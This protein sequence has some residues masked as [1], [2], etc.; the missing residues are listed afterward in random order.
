MVT[1]SVEKDGQVVRGANPKHN[2]ILNQG[3]D[4]IASYSFADCFNYCAAGDSNVI[5]TK[6]DVAL[7]NELSRTGT[8]SATGSAN[9]AEL[10]NNVFKLFRT[11]EFAIEV[12]DVIYRE[13]GMSPFGVPGSNI[14]SKALLRDNAGDPI[15]VP[16]ATGE[17]LV[18]KYELYIEIFDAETQIG[19][20]INGRANSSGI[21]RIQKIGLKGIS[22][23]GDTEDYDVVGSCNEPSTQ[24]SMFISTDNSPPEPFGQC[25]DRSAGA[26]EDDGSISNYQAST[27]RRN[28]SLLIRP[29][30]LASS[31]RSVG[32]GPAANNGAVFVFDQDQNKESNKAYFIN[33]TYFWTKRNL[34]NFSPWL[35]FED[36]VYLSNRYN[37]QNSFAYFAL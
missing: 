11:F 8:K 26:Y 28:K 24:A 34:S 7:G 5:P 16:V 23:L 18:V 4:F 22:A 10:S 17:K 27:Y 15:D 14:F 33:F 20:A 1:W 2:L 21:L 36:A 30:D 9:G 25:I 29:A 35:D 32:V 6:T 3:L 19:T 31:W 37:K 13:V 12:S